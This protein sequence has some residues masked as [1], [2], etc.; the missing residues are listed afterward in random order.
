MKICPKCDTT[1]PDAV[2]FCPQDGSGLQE[3][4]EWSEGCVVRGKYRILGKVGQGGMGAVYKALHIPFNEIRALKVI[5][6]DLMRDDMFVKRFR[7]EAV[8]ARKL[9]HPNA[10]RVDDIDEADDGRPLIVMEFIEGRNLKGL[11]GAFGPLPVERVCLVARQVASALEAAHRMGMVHR[12]IKPA[13]IVLVP[14]PEGEQAKVLDFGIAK[15]KEAR[16]PETGLNT[17]TGTGMVVGTPQY[18]SP[19]QA[20]GKRGDDLDGRSDLYSLGIVMYQMLTGEVPFKGETTMQVLFA[21]VHTS[22]KPI[23]EVRPDLKVPIPIERI[24]M[25]C[26]EKDRDLRPANAGTLIEEIEQAEA[27]GARVATIF[28]PATPGSEETVATL[29]MPRDAERLAKEQAERESE[30]QR[31]RD[32]SRRRIFESDTAAT[33]PKKQGDTAERERRSA[34][35]DSA[36]ESRQSRLTREQF[37]H[38]FG[39]QEEAKP[40]P[41]PQTRRG[42]DASGRLRVRPEQPGAQQ[43]PPPRLQTGSVISQPAASTG[44]R[45]TGAL[46][47]AA[48]VILLGAGAWYF[49]AGRHAS[50]NQPSA[51]ATANLPPASQPSQ[52]PAATDENSSAQLAAPANSPPAAPAPNSAAENIAPPTNAKPEAPT[53]AELATQHRVARLVKSGDRYLREKNYPRAIRTYESGLKLDPTNSAL[54]DKLKEARAAQQAPRTAVAANE[55]HSAPPSPAA[56]TP[57]ADTSS[58]AAEASA[59]ANTPPQPAVPSTGSLHL[60]A[61]AGAAIYIDGKLVGKIADGGSVL[62]SHV[63]A[64]GHR[65]RLALSGYQN[66]NGSINVLPGQT[67]SSAITLAAVP[68]LKVVS[69]HVT[70]QHTFG[71]DSGT[72]TIGN[73]RISYESNKK[74]NSFDVPISSIAKYGTVRYGADFYFE[75]QNGKDYLFNG[76]MA[77]LQ[78]YERAR[79]AAGPSLGN[80]AGQSQN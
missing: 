67:T 70:H 15:I 50:P 34:D 75:L 45:K 13:N 32:E 55:S 28:T 17:L 71:S 38:I 41:V 33:P 22:A 60:T 47:I 51:A 24:V 49:Y 62:V 21:Q 11:I 52:P 8:F 1:F 25:R 6:P 2:A 43:T 27:K 79:A 80:K 48:A 44:S 16:A 26:L 63:P 37:E 61:P 76:P 3:Q 66:W 77:V 12:D 54:L 20:L 5:R 35:Q 9:Q 14:S 58:P 78:A 19:E 10:V 40:E 23:H 39:K 4:G 30:A 42:T 59:P 7:Q 18:M 36:G 31:R 57:V 69:F 46:L 56:V 74:S 53:S 64:G 65:V 73:G 29:L 68:Q 72:L